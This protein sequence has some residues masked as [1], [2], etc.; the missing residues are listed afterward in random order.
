MPRVQS[1][2]VE[3]VEHDPRRRDLIVTYTGGETYAYAGVERTTYEA[4]L[5]ADSIGRFVN[6]I[7]KPTHPVRRLTARPALAR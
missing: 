6:D 2:A 5:A 3:A 7:I 1:T 4:L